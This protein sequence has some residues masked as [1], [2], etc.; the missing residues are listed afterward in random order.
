M[1]P[2]AAQGLSLAVQEETVNLTAIVA[3]TG[4][5]L[6]GRASVGLAPRLSRRLQCRASESR[7]VVG[8]LEWRLAEARVVSRSSM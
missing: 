2:R 4:R 3:R 1:E 5:A 7:Q 6:A 8:H